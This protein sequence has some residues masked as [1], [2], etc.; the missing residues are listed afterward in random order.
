MIQ[1][2]KA[3]GSCEKK[4]EPD[5]SESDLKK[6][7]RAMLLIRLLDARMMGLQRQGRIGFYGTAT[8]EEAAV[9]GSA[10]ALKREDWIFPALRQGGAALLRGYPLKLYIAQCMANSLDVQKGRQ[11]PCHYSYKPANFV[12]WGSCIGTQLPH[13]VGAAYAAKLKKDPIVVM[14]YLGDGATSSGDF[15]AAMNFAGVWRVPVVFF[16]QNN[17]W[18]ISVPRRIQTATE[19]LAQKALA[20]GFEGI[21]VDGNDLLAVYKVA[22]EAVEKARSGGGPTLIEAVTYRIGGHSTADDPTRYRNEREVEE[23]KKKDP[24]ERFKLYLKKKGIWSEKYEEQ[25]Q[26]EI[27]NEISQAIKEAE[28]APPP[29]PQTLFED[30]YKEMPWHLKEQFA[31]LQ[32]SGKI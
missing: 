2:L 10:Y 11:Q 9:I 6:I 26:A 13:A 3:D 15:H 5:L 20:Y 32:Q 8:G 18:A 4:L 21:Q 29:A 24:I 23:W 16:C 27:E 30:V 25:L 22:K 12:A 17:Q 14:A 1:V 28:A 7:Y 31:S 19:T